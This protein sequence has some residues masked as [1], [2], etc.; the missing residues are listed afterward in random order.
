MK[1]I[2]Q[3]IQLGMIDKA[4]SHVPPVSFT[5]VQQAE[6]LLYCNAFCALVKVCF[7]LPLINVNSLDSVQK[8]GTAGDIAHMVEEGRAFKEVSCVSHL[9]AFNH[10]CSRGKS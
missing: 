10:R 8:I 6:G 9:N 3:L 1:V 2:C 7:T 5:S 4:T